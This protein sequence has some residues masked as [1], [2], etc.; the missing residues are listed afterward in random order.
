MNFD[1]F[2]GNIH[3]SRVRKRI[4]EFSISS[5]TVT[6]FNKK[7]LDILR[8]FISIF[9]IFTIIYNMS[10]MSSNFFNNRFAKANIV[11]AHNQFFFRAAL[12]KGPKIIFKLQNERS[13][14]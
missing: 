5:K 11:Q 10:A 2:N 13:S 6:H 9:I 14:N 12:V 7:I 4:F 3:T 1:Q 8:D